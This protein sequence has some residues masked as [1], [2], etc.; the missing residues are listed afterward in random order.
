MCL[1]EVLHWVDCRHQLLQVA[2]S[3]L[4]WVL[5][6]C[7]QVG[8]AEVYLVEPEV[9]TREELI[10]HQTVLL[11]AM[12]R[13]LS[14]LPVTSAGMCHVQAEEGFTL[15]A[16]LETAQEDSRGGDRQTPEKMRRK[17]NLFKCVVG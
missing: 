3:A 8:G 13:T 17:D 9:R 16:M 2:R 12:G 5:R 15:R 4:A 6:H 11:L 1:G 14:S 7:S 10:A